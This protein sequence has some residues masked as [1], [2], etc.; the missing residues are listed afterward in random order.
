MIGDKS[1]FEEFE[2]YFLDLNAFKI[3]T[4]IFY[5]NKFGKN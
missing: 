1:L 5:K 2:F 3:Y 4:V